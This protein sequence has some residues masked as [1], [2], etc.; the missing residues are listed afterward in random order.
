MFLVPGD[1]QGLTHS[2]P[3]ECDSRQAIQAR[4]DHPYRV[5]SPSRGFPVDMHQ[6]APTSDLFSTRFNNKLAQFVS[7]LASSRSP[8][9]G[10]RCS[11]PFMGESG[12][13]CLPTGSLLEESGGEA[14]GEPMQ[15]T[16]SDCSNVQHALAWGLSDHLEP[17][18]CVCPICPTCLS[19]TLLTEICQT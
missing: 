13:I 8:G 4:P 6:V 19:I 14:A 7:P 12:P 15:E 3:A 2:R 16:H 18:P 17:D 10:S 9:L 5:V 1:S 11:Q